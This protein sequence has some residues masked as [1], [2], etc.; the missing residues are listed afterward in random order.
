M[1]TAERELTI[2]LTAEDGSADGQGPPLFAGERTLTTSAVA[3]VRRLCR[4]VEA[5]LRCDCS[6]P[7]YRFVHNLYRHVSL[8]LSLS[9]SPSLPPSLS[10]QCC[11]GAGAAAA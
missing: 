8:S 5:E 6:V 3:T 11:I 9:L 1:A 2:T 10:H 7:R 4:A